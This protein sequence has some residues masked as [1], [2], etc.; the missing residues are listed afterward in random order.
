MKNVTKLFS[1]WSKRVNT[2][3]HA[4]NKENYNQISIH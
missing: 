3:D 1:S 4:I 2:L